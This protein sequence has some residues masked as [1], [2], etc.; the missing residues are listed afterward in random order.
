MQSTPRQ[1]R[2]A[3]LRQKL[4]TLAA[5]LVE[6]ENEIAALDSDAVL[7]LG[8]THSPQSAPLTPAEKVALFLELFGTRR[9]VYPKRWENN[10]TGKNGYS[11][12]CDNEWRAGICQKPKVKCSE[13]L[14]Q[15]FPALD[16]AAIEAHLRAAITRLECMPSTRMTPAAF[17]RR[18]SMAKTGE[19]MCWR[20]ARQR[21][22]SVS[23]SPLNARVRVTA[24]MAGYSLRS[25]FPRSL[26]EGWERFW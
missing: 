3:E 25:R 20:I 17:S 21:N 7:D 13:C 8:A 26:R 18:T 1:Q 6:T 24:L 11:P 4:A 12:A 10:K 9:T 19:T 14:H 15:R 22:G 5:E 23:R 16:E 2:V